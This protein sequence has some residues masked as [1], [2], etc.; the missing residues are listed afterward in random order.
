MKA[1]KGAART[2]AARRKGKVIGSTPGVGAVGRWVEYP[3]SRLSFRG[4]RAA[5]A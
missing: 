1:T 5:S 2:K 4:A 3:Q